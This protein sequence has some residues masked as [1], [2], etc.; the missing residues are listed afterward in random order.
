MSKKKGKSSEKTVGQNNLTPFTKG[1]S[2]NPNGR[3]PRTLKVVNAELQAR[4]IKPVTRADIN[5]I[6][7]SLIN[8]N[9]EEVARLALSKTEP[10]VVSLIARAIHDKKG[11]D[12]LEKMLDRTLGRPTQ[13]IDM[14]TKG[15]ITIREV[16]VTK[17][18]NEQRN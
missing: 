9:R 3:P 12:I 16:I 13:Q 11:F 2:G 10:I 18:L 8:L 15:E 5:F 17:P 7:N 6:Y 14:E 1:Q 4:G